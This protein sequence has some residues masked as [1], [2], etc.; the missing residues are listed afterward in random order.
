[1]CIW[2]QSLGVLLCFRLFDNLV[3]EG[4]SCHPLLSVSS[5]LG[6]D[7]CSPPVT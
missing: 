1:M 6:Y 4:L 7:I 3:E 5:Y 2:V